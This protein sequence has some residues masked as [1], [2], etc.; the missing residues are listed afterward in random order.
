[1]SNK[2]R[3]VV[4]TGLGPVTAAGIGVAGL[5]AGLRAGRSPV[6]TVSLFDPTPFRST[7]AAQV[8][9]E[10]T[11]Y[12]DAK[13]A[14]R[15]DRFVQFALAASHLAM[16]D[17]GLSNARAERGLD[18]ETGSS[19]DLDPTRTAIQLGSAMGGIAHAENELR[20]F[21]EKGART[22][23]PRLATTTFAGA[24]SCQIAVRLGIT[25][26]NSTNAMSCAAGTMA[27][28]EAAR[29]IRDGI[30]DVALAGGADAP[31]AP[32]CYG[33][34]A[35]LRAMSTRNDEPSRSCRP[36]DV[37]RDGFVMGEGACI[38]ILEEGSKAEA[39]GARIYAEISGYGTNNDAYHMAAPRPDGAMAVEAIRDALDM[40]GLAPDAVD[41]VNAHASSTQLNDRTES[42]VIRQALTTRADDVSVP[43]T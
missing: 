1:M 8:D 40:A 11:E 15:T 5:R 37:D 28:G 29:L 17:A 22:L 19:L 24:A 3:R 30:V 10:P 16:H 20:T 39:R 36:F 12:M 9:F 21:V 25:G 27:I 32:V 4:V 26:P 23:D 41:H 35:S 13:T 34:F 33:A 43:G 18:E 2:H 42:Q 31:L 6:A 14:R 7:M 38:L